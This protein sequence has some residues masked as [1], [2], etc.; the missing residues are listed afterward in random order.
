MSTNLLGRGWV[1]LVAA[2]VMGL[3]VT[4]YAE[5]EPALGL[6]ID[7]IPEQQC[8]TDGLFGLNERLAESAIEIALSATH[9]Y[10]VNTHGGA[11]THD[12]AG[13]ISGSYDLEVA[14]DLER[15]LG[16]GGGSLF[17]LAEGSWP[18]A[19]GI[20]DEA[21]GSI[22]G[23]NDDAGGHRSIDVT[24]L[25]YE[26]ALLG[27]TVKVRVGKVDLTGGFACRGCAVAFDGSAFAND[28]T[29][30]FLNGALVNNPAIPFPDNG[31]GFAVYYQN[32]DDCWYVAVG[33]ADAYADGRE[34]GFRTGMHGEDDFFQIAEVGVT[35]AVEGSHGPLQ[36]AY[37]FGLWRDPQEKLN[38]R[39]GK[40][41]RRDTGCY[42][43]FDQMIYRER[44]DDSQGLGVFGRYGWDKSEFA[45]VAN[46]WSAGLQY[47]GL[48]PR[49]EDD[50]MGCA[51]ARGV[52]SDAGEF[53]ADSETVMEVYYNAHVA[54]WFNVTP[55][56][57]YIAN[58]GGADGN[59]DA[60]VLALRVQMAF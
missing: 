25:W 40:L 14:A 27:D 13:R 29:N 56:L 34:T 15:M 35:P 8:L 50:V 20:N 11:S 18:T 37:R 23:V 12:H 3:W 4:A 24:E 36:G 44:S 10:Q 7:E 46:F 52:F 53:N 28:E 39:T 2:V 49:R 32:P 60:T 33:A 5:N 57:Q 41:E 42:V 9:V 16:I 26:Q 1:L 22:F 38:Q 45:E 17:I 59:S 31:L 30:Q 43:S 54:G 51:L 6:G 48:L 47:Q 55:S 21:V 19:E 58:P